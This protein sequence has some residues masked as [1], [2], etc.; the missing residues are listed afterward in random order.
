MARN[1]A[2][3]A[4][5]SRPA[6]PGCVVVLWSKLT[7]PPPS[8]KLTS[9]SENSEYAPLLVKVAVATPAKAPGPKPSG[10]ARGLPAGGRL[11][12]APIAPTGNRFGPKS[13]TALPGLAQDLKLTEPPAPVVSTPPTLFCRTTGPSGPAVK[14]VSSSRTRNLAP[15]VVVMEMSFSSMPAYAVGRTIAGFDSPMGTLMVRLPT[16]PGC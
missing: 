11:P 16:V 4:A 9:A 14:L 8:P 2:P 12:T 1:G 15:P 5:S 6:G 13:G 7:V 10:P 3:A